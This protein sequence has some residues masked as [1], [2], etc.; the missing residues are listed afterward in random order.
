MQF[1]L[2]ATL[3]CSS[4][5]SA[6][7]H[8]YPHSHVL[9]VS[10][11]VP[12]SLSLMLLLVFPRNPFLFVHV[13]I[14]NCY[15]SIIPEKLYEILQQKVLSEVSQ[16]QPKWRRNHSC[17]VC[18]IQWPEDGSFTL[19]FFG[20]VPTSYD[21]TQLCLFPEARLEECLTRPPLH[22]VSN[23]LHTTQLAVTTFQYSNVMLWLCILVLSFHSLFLFFSADCEPFFK[24]ASDLSQNT[25]MRNTILTDMVSGDPHKLYCF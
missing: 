3:S 4:W 7:C 13:D 21:A 11:L 24:F 16:G 22:G 6:F 18:M 8:Q 14:C 10:F 1:I 23:E 19:S 15:D 12:G 5:Q 2:H 17:T 20:R 25:S 9:A